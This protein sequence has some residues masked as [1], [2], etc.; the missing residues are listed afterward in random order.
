ME[1]RDEGGSWE[2]LP[3][4]APTEVGRIADVLFAPLDAQL[5]LLASRERG[6]FRSIDGGKTWQVLGTPAN[7]L[8]SLQVLRLACD[9]EERRTRVLYATHGDAAAG[10]SKSIDGGKTWFGIAEHLCAQEILLEAGDILVSARRREE[11]GTWGIYQS[12]DSGETFGESARDVRCTA[13]G[14]NR[15][16]HAGVWFGVQKGKLLHRVAIANHEVIPDWQP[17]GPPKDGQWAS[18]FGS[19]GRDINDDVLYAYDPA[20]YGLVASRDEFKT[21]WTENSGLF[22]GP[23]VKEGASVCASANGKVLYA[24]INGQLYVGRL[25]GPAEGPVIV[26]CEITP[27]VVKWVKDGP[28]QFTAKVLPFDKDPKSKIKQ[29]WANIG[30][31]RGPGNFALVAPASV[32]A[33][34]DAG[35]TLDGVFSGTFAM[36]K[37]FPANWHDRRQGIP[38]EIIIQV[39][40]RDDKNRQT[41]EN[42]P[43]YVLPKPESFVYWDGE[44]VR[45]GGKLADGCR[46]TYNQRFDP[47]NGIVDEIETD[48]HA[49]KRCLRVHS[50]RGPWVSGWGSSW[51]A[52]KNLTDMDYVSFWIKGHAASK[53][54]VKVML[55]D[56]P[57]A[58]HEPHLSS[59]VWLIKDGFL[60]ELKTDYQQVRVPI[61]KFLRKTEFILDVCGGIAFGG[62]DP[63][64]HNFYVDDICMEVEGSR[65]PAPPSTPQK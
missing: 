54:D 20:Q 16:K 62:D 10:I 33:G 45:W 53:T 43:L 60:Q 11:D 42:L 36:G 48:A 64:G 63:E 22:D 41:A 61:T 7:G 39:S 17:V 47:R 35:Q 44:N 65:D 38:G 34:K 58:G 1:S 56:A 29:V 5:I 27:S 4:T 40:A 2:L 59:A 12:Q 55:S 51:T 30:H 31:I 50:A 21:W 19:F 57:S 6:I 14:V 15:I 23:L 37:D 8:K 18:I 46:S 25:A 49:G 26:S 3:S 52:G 13:A 28:I 9:E 32:P 24:S